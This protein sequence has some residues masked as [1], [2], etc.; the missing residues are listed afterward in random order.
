MRQYRE[1]HSVARQYPRRVDRCGYRQKTTQHEGEFN[2]IPPTGR[3][4][5]LRAMAKFL[6]DDG[7]VTEHREYHD[8]QDFLEQLGVTD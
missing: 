1:F 7:K 5:E 8:R 2:D 4:V 6:V 3:E